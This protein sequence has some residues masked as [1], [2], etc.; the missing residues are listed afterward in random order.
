MT[1]RRQIAVESGHAI[2]FSFKV[3]KTREPEQQ[4]ELGTYNGDLGTKGIEIPWAPSRKYRVL[5]PS[6]MRL[7]QNF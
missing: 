5:G 6:G 1:K 2:V 7:N 4:S 3:M